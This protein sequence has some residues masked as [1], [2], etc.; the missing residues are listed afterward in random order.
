ML[1]TLE[2]FRANYSNDFTI[3]NKDILHGLENVCAV[4]GLQGRWQTLQLKPKV[5]TDT[6]HNEAGIGFVC[7]QLLQQNFDTLRIVIGFANDKDISKILK[8]LP[9]NAKYYFTQANV[10]RAMEADELAEKALSVG[11]KG[12]FHNSVEESVKA[13]INEAAPE[14]LIFIGGSNFVVGEAIPLFEK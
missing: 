14:D 4:T 1:K 5:I 2:V 7:E 13:A 6:G 3:D 10:Q 12:C 8:I 11:L 9:A